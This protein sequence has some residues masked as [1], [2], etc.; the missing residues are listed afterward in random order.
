MF[1]L[2]MCLGVPTAIACIRYVPNPCAVSVPM[3]K[4]C[5]SAADC[6]HGFSPDGSTCQ[7]GYAGGFYYCY[8]A[9][10][11]G[12]CRWVIRQG[13]CV[14]GKCTSPQQVGTVII[15]GSTRYE[16]NVELPCP[17]GT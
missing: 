8:V 6:I 13:V 17:S 14:N 11:P 16:A 7:G 10:V 9:E 2:A 15:P 12:G 1:I 5:N 3:A 4:T